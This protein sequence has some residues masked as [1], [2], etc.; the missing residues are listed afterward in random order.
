[1][2]KEDAQAAA[3]WRDGPSQSRHQAWGSCTPGV[4]KMTD[5]VLADTAA[6]GPGSR[7]RLAH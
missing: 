3:A 2:G 5:D 1:M 4:E 6:P 7:W